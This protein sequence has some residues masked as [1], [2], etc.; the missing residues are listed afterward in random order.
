MANFS[1]HLYGGALVSSV[2]SLAVFGLGWTDPALTQ[3]LFLAGVAG[4]LLPD[5]D[6]DNS[7]PVRGFFTLLGA[8]FAFLASFAM[9]G[10]LLPRELVVVWVVVFVGVRFGLFELFS[11]CTVH[12]G[13]C[14]SWLAAGFSALAALNGAFHLV[15][16]SARESWLVGIFVALGYLTHLFLD[17]SASVDLLRNRVKRSFGTALKP[18][19]MAAPGASLTMFLGAIALA[20][21]AP[22]VDPI[23]AAAAGVQVD[24]ISLSITV[25]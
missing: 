16:F 25:R 10:R 2:G 7:T 20:F 3:M 8:L 9:L 1:T 12:R 17:E 18:F 5:I 11:R 15:G 4:G 6:A 13:L 21:L 23:L 19:S 14:H 24:G 22:P